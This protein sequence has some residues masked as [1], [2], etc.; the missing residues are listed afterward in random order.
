M[1]ISPFQKLKVI[2]PFRFE[3]IHSKITNRKK[4]VG[5]ALKMKMMMNKNKC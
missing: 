5:I 1:S 2:Y 4:K 3:R